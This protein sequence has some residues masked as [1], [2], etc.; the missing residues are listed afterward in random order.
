VK[1]RTAIRGDLDTSGPKDED[2][3]APLA[4]FHTLKVLLA[5]AARRQHHVYQADYVGAYLH[6]KMDSVIHVTLPAALAEVFPDLAQWFGVPLLFEK[7]AYGINAAGRL[8]AEE[9]FTWYLEYGFTQSTVDLHVTLPA[10]L[11]EVFPDLAEWFGVPLLFEKAAYGINA[12]GRLWAEEQFTWYL[13]YGFTQSTVDPSL[14]YYTKGEDWIVLLSYC[15]DTAYFASTDEVRQRFETAMCRRFECKLMNQMHWF[16]QA[17]ITQHENFDITIDQSRYA[18]SMCSRFLPDH[19]LA[20]PSKTDPNTYL[21]RTGGYHI[22]M[23]G[24]IV[25]SAMTFPTPVALS[26]A[27]AEYNNA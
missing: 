17:R 3:S 21:A 6:A 18:V 7:A 8:W 20:K 14:F 26:T 25:N 15:D 9:Q 10:A 12:A 22:F 23:Q 11:A 24:G 5:E 19:E 1:L 16:L 2:N 13:E 27:E 4:T